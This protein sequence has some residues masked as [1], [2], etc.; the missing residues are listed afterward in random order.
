MP[1]DFDFKRL[2]RDAFER[3]ESESIDYAVMEKTDQ[4]VVMPMDAGWSDIG[5]WNVLWEQ[6]DKDECGNAIKGDVIVNDASDAYI[7]AESRLVV[8]RRVQ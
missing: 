2:H 1:V 8:A 3:C 7:Y 5:S 6:G 4:A